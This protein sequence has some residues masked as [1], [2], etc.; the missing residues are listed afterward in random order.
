MKK[1]EKKNSQRFHKCHPN[2]ITIGIPTIN[3]KMRRSVGLYCGGSLPARRHASIC[4]RSRASGESGWGGGRGR[5][6]GGEMVKGL[7]GCEG[8]GMVVDGVVEEGVGFGVE[9]IVFGVEEAVFGIGIEASIFP[10]EAET[11]F[12]SGPRSGA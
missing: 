8:R 11:I 7:R 10:V 2:T 4:W 6:V 3:P 9:G 12:A 5:G 1:K